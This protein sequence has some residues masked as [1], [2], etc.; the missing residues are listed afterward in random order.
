MALQPTELDL[1]KIVFKKQNI[2]EN[3]NFIKIDYPEKQYFNIKVIGYLND[4]GCFD[5]FGKFQF[6]LKLRNQ[7]DYIQLNQLD[8]MIENDFKN[9]I[10]N[11]KKYVESFGKDIINSYHPLFKK[12]KLI[13]FKLQMIFNEKKSED[14]FKIKSNKTIAVKDASRIYKPDQKCQVLFE[15]SIYINAAGYG[16]CKKVVSITFL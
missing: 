12:N 14:I 13:N 5:N 3:N 16:W 8:I 11:N 15:P 1:T 2:D 6:D 10:K 4:Y 7:Q 9:I